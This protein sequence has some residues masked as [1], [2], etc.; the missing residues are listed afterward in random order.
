MTDSYVP[1]HLLWTFVTFVPLLTIVVV[2]VV[3][4]KSCS[5]DGFEG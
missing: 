5:F 3:G 4:L 1:S 2:F